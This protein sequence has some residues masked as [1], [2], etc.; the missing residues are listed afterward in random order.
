MDD[1]QGKPDADQAPTEPSLFFSL[2]D[3]SEN[4][5]MFDRGTDDII[6]INYGTGQ[7]VV[8]IKQADLGQATGSPGVTDLTYLDSITSQQIFALDTVSTSLLLM[9]VD[10]AFFPLRS[11][12]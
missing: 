9:R 10:Y 12:R 5:A 6:A 1:L 11:G 4:R 3:L 2:N 8:V 7:Y